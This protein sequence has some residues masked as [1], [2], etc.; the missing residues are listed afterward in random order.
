MSKQDIHRKSTD[1][2]VPIRERVNALESEVKCCRLREFSCIRSNC[3]NQVSCQ[4]S[5]S[6]RARSESRFYGTVVPR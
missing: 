5:F 2:A 6:N 3:L 1:A 4:T